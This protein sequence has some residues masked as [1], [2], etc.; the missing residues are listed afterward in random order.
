MDV[1][2]VKL[3]GSLITRNESEKYLRQCIEALQ[4]FCDEIRAVDDNSTDGTHTLM[5]EMGVQ[6]LRNDRSM[7]Y[8]HEGRARQTLLEWT[9]EA[10]PTHILVVDGDE[11]VE[12]GDQ[13]R[14]ALEAPQPA[15]TLRERRQ[16]GRG[17][18]EPITV[19]RLQMQEVWGATDDHLLI[20]Q[21]GGWKEHPVPICYAIP[22]I[23]H[24]DRRS[25]R[26]WRIPDRALACGRVP[27]EVAVASNRSL[28]AAAATVLHLGWACQ[29]D[30]CARHQRYVVHD[31]GAH[32]A[33]KHLDSIMW[34]DSRVQLSSR[35]WPDG[36]DKHK[37]LERI[38]RT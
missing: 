31:G 9:M 36:V 10:E 17:G 19:W 5:T 18:R 4:G 6:V 35:P 24:G 16:R 20:R 23:A 30:R 8:E 25:I 29:A 7:F 15:L 2:D 13:L 1:A 27:T 26:N 28:N 14:V 33:S 3:V 22:G 32:H 37:I 11:L 21:D 34:D 38:N 12:N